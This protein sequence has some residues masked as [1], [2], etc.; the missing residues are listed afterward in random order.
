MVN[1]QLDKVSDH[2][3]I[4]PGTR[5][6]MSPESWISH[7]KYNKKFDIFS[8]GV[9]MVQTITMLPPKLSDRVDSS[10]KIVPEIMRRKD[11]LFQI[12]GHPL[13]DLVSR[14]LQ[15]NADECPTAGKICPS[16][17]FMQSFSSLVVSLSFV[18]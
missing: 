12:N 10:N 13:Q 18:P 5:G 14:C 2:T 3:T 17:P 7:S 4:A 11:H 6:Y 9:L 1:I 8:F 16:Y 15:D